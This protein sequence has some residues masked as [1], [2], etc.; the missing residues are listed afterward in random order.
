MVTQRGCW[1]WRSLKS[2]RRN[3]PTPATTTPP[4]ATSTT[5]GRPDGVDL[6][7][8]GTR[9]RDRRR[10][11][12]TDHGTARGRGGSDPATVP[13]RPG[14]RCGPVAGAGRPAPGGGGSRR[15]DVGVDPV[16]GRRRRDGGPGGVVAQAVR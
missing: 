9:R 8:G 2:G 6:V 13:G 16:A 5:A 1:M 11:P 14:D 3:W 4:P 7:A 15:G 12:A 10:C